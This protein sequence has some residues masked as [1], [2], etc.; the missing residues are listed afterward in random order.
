MTRIVAFDLDGTLIDSL[1]L[2][3]GRKTP[4][5]LIESDHSLGIDYKF[6]QQPRTWKAFPNVQET[7]GKL[8][9]Q[10][11]L[12][13]VITRSPH[14]YAST[15]LHFIGASYT[16]LISSTGASAENKALILQ[17]WAKKNDVLNSD[18]LYVGDEDIDEEIARRTGCK[19]AHASDI[20]NGSLLSMPPA[21]LPISKHPGPPPD[22][23]L[24]FFKENYGLANG[25]SHD[26]TTSFLMG[27]PDP[28][29]HS[30]MLYAL[31]DTDAWEKFVHFPF[32]DLTT[33]PELRR[34]LIARL[35]AISL[36]L[37]PNTRESKVWQL[38]SQLAWEK[39]IPSRCL[40]Q[41]DVDTG[42][43]GM[44]SAILNRYELHQ[45]Q[46]N[47]HLFPYLRLLQSMFPSSHVTINDHE[48]TPSIPL[49]FNAMYA[50][51][52]KQSTG[53]V[54]KYIKDF[55]NQ[56]GPEISLGLFDFVVDIVASSVLNFV[57]VNL[58]K[59][60][61]DHLLIVPV[62]STTR[63]PSSPGEISNR[64]AAMVTQRLSGQ[65]FIK[66]EYAPILNRIAK[67]SFELQESVAGPKNSSDFPNKF[68]VL[69]IEDQVT[70][71]NATREAVRVLRESRYTVLSVFSYSKSRVN[72]AEL[73]C[74]LAQIGQYIGYRCS[75]ID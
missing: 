7:M 66:M 29:A 53:G 59:S 47:R 72:P 16:A 74:C 39:G 75:C 70:N 20:W 4:W 40:Y 1:A 23:G 44:N 38:M 37:R 35:A 17:T 34:T 28:S 12:V 26:L 2:P 25:L 73:N 49:R 71:G 9:R 43:F 48:D 33:S 55:N 8:L 3:G 41:L 11:Y 45:L 42:Y 56:S 57:E 58:L 10:G 14:A 31:S 63:S 6:S 30:R 15:A 19:F 13:L 18:V 32:A 54:M 62:P 46:T 69:L 68:P 24:E 61:S 22:T 36:L 27:I 50:P 21:D 60:S 5:Y 67:N 52:D 64:L 65:D 51:A